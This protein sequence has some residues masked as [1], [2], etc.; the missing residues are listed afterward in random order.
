MSTPTLFPTD[1]KRRF[2]ATT[3]DRFRHMTERHAKKK[4]PPPPFT[5]S[6]L[7]EH[8]IALATNGSFQCRYCRGWFD[9]SEVALDHAV[10]FSR[11]GGLGLDNIE[12]PCAPC[13]AAKAEM[14]PQEFEA[15]LA[16]LETKIPFARTDILKRLREHS[17]L[18]AGKRKAEMLLRNGGE[19]PKKTKPGKPALVAAI[20]DDF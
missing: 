2:T 17:K 12:I 15:L 8:I 4:L 19:F 5:L 20:D 9:I 13:N 3:A 11:G 10:P 18:L 16:F 7:R 14:T 1:A 6:E